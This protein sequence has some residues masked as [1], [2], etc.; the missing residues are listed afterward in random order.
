MLL[1]PNVFSMNVPKPDEAVLKK[2]VSFNVLGEI[3]ILPISAIK[4]DDGFLHTLVFGQVPSNKDENGHIML[5]IHPQVFE[6]MKCFL[7]CGGVP[8]SIDSF[9]LEIASEFFLN[10]KLREYVK[11]VLAPKPKANEAREYSVLTRER[12]PALCP[13]CCTKVE[14][15]PNCGYAT[16]IFLE[17]L[18]NQ[19]CNKR[20][21]IENQDVTDHKIREGDIFIKISFTHRQ[22][23]N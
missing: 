14:S 21:M 11:S 13:I 7:T 9:F 15:A 10:S 3:K 18:R 2:F 4:A 12:F 17:H 23:E 5:E 22:I 20:E 19:H 8:A 6:V 1:N 16:K